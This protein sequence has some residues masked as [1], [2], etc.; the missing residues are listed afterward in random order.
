MNI[1]DLYQDLILDHGTNPRNY[2]A[3]DHAMCEADGFNPFCGDNLH[4]YC[5]LDQENKIYNI[6]FTGSGCAISMASASILTEIAKNKSHSEM[7][8]IFGYFKQCLG[9]EHTDM[10][11]MSIDQVDHDRLQALSGVKKFPSRIKCA[12]LAW[13]ALL[14][15][16]AKSG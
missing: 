9:L 16:V 1:E 2:F 4:I 12:T 5:N 7:I 8:N 11:I 13:H 6:S 14:Q 10:S 3:Q 15:A